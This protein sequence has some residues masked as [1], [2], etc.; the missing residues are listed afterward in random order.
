ME[1]DVCHK[2]GFKNKW[3]IQVHK[4]LKHKEANDMPVAPKSK[5]K[6]KMRRKPSPV[7]EQAIV[8]QPVRMP[9]SKGSGR[10]VFI[11]VPCKVAVEF[12]LFN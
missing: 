8:Q 1:C 9:V 6:Y 7:F 5:R 2:D 4:A 10:D 12:G 11:L 3:G